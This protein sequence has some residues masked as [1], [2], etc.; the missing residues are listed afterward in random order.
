MYVRVYC[1]RRLLAEMVPSRACGALGAGRQAP[2]ALGLGCRG[3]SGVGAEKR[4]AKERKKLID[5]GHD[6]DRSASKVRAGADSR[7]HAD[8]A[9]ARCAR[10][11]QVGGRVANDDAISWRASESPAHPQSGLC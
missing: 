9:E 5:R 11:G 3:A 1:A 7:E 6:G 10:H 4:Q 2:R 8:P